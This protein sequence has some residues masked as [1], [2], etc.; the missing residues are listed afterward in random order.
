MKEQQKKHV[1]LP[2]MFH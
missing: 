1:V 2:V